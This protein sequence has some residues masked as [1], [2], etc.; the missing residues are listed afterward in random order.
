[1][2]IKYT[3]IHGNE[4]VDVSVALR[5]HVAESSLY[6]DDAAVELRLRQ[7][8]LVELLAKMLERMAERGLVDAADLVEWLEIRDAFDPEISF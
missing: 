1:M 2:L 7:N 5:R 3:N 8:T 6:E 4:A